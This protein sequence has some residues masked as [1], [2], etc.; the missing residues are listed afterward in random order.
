[1]KAPSNIAALV[2]LTL[3]AALLPACGAHKME[4]YVIRGP[5][6]Q[7]IVTDRSDAR[8]K[9]QPLAGASV[10]VT[11]DP[12]SLGRRTLPIVQSGPDGSFAVPIDEVGAGLLDYPVLIVVRKTNHDTAA[13]E[14]YL[15]SG[16]KCILAVLKPGKD[17][18]RPLD[19]PLRESE[20][21]LP[22]SRKPGS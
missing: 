19:D 6:S 7:V 11:I 14:I 13:T 17:G 1:M 22:P 4:G 3:A 15:P 2:L 21:F 5:A 8:I 12:Q 18:Y 16:F 20:P 9:Q 10:Q